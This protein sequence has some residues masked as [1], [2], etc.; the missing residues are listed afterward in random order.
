MS[1][2][3]YV[4]LTATLSIGLSQSSP[5]IT[6][7]SSG[8]P[9]AV[10]V[11]PKGASPTE[12]FAAAE[13]Q[14][15]VERATGA[16]LGIASEA[17][18]DTPHVLVQCGGAEL[19]E[20]LGEEGVLIEAKGHRLLLSGGGE[21]GTLYA[22]YVF[23]ED[24]LG[25]R[26]FAPGERGEWVPKAGSVEVPDMTVRRKPAFRYRSFT[27][28][29]LPPAGAAAGSVADWMVKNRINVVGRNWPEDLSQDE[30]L[31][32]R[33][34]AVGR[35][36]THSWGRRIPPS[37]TFSSHPEYFA[38]TRDRRL[39]SN[40]W[41]KLCTTN[42]E[43]IRLMAGVAEE[44]VA[45]RTRDRV[46]SLTES[47]GLG[48]CTCP[49]CRALDDDRTW[50][51]GSR[52]SIPVVSN[53][54]I[55]FVNSVAS[56]AKVR[57]NVQFYVLAYHADFPPSKAPI[58]PRPNV[59]VQA[60]HSRPNFNCFTH[61]VTHDCPRNR[62][63]REHLETWI[64][65]TP[66]VTLYDYILHSQ[67]HQMPWIAPRKIVS[68]T[69][70]Y[71]EAGLDGFVWQCSPSA[72]AVRGLNYYAAAQAMWNPDLEVEGLVRDFCHAFFR[73]AAKEVMAYLDFME[74]ARLRAPCINLGP[75]MLLVQEAE[76]QSDD[77]T[78]DEFLT[79]DVL[80]GAT[81]LLNAAWAAAQTDET[82]RQIDELRTNLEYAKRFRAA[83]MAV[84]G[85]LAGKADIGPVRK[86][87]LEFQDWLSQLSGGRPGVGVASVQRRFL[88]GAMRRVGLNPT[89]DYLR[90]LA[91]SKGSNLVPNPGGETV[92]Q[93]PL[94]PLDYRH[95]RA[96]MSEEV[97]VGWGC[98]VGGGDCRWGSSTETPHSGERCVFVE[99][100]KFHASGPSQGSINVGLMPALTNGYVGRQALAAEGNATYEFSFWLRGNVPTLSVV[101]AGWRTT[102]AG[103]SSRQG[104]K[105]SLKTIHPT[106]EWQKFRGRLTTASDTK[107]FTLRV[108][109]GG[110]V[111]TGAKLGTFCLDDVVIKKAE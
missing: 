48:W 101:G 12:R 29:P 17:P 109:A 100:T 86:E 93:R 44:D 107:R 53:R 103:K 47:D 65:I 61:P 9:A 14:H 2:H 54:M 31:A 32:C 64:R 67:M 97:P 4:A 90:M 8:Q 3:T 27:S 83:R 70:Y 57:P 84:V 69:R 23:L 106:S 77:H 52:G 50:R 35:W 91:K 78:I 36:N 49:H 30:F 16:K 74:M 26:W 55:T 38:V 87:L 40:K 46:Y 99:L 11:L 62:K 82:H 66:S 7:V 71:R 104:L 18:A 45:K 60:V 85:Y 110:N 25:V 37:D 33:G 111:A 98:Y 56:R 89:R 59:M 19:A 63:F 75:N 95:P 39:A 24:H 58:R 15:Y 81:E 73:E 28:F 10:I 5:A 94:F 80:A 102:E 43:M 76:S 13:L 20:E 41:G 22:V 72:S 68:D 79:P 51:H 105:C 108:H 42:Q 21:R 6:L 34:G 96:V 1:R 92:C 88:R